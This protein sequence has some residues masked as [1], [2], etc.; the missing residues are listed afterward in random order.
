MTQ[1]PTLKIGFVGSGH[2][3]RVHAQALHALGGAE[4]IAWS[5]QRRERAL[6]A[7]RDFG[8]EA[9]T[10]DALLSHAGLEIAIITTPTPQHAEQAITA[11]THGKQVF[12][13]KPMARTA[14]QADD[15]IAAAAR[16]QRKLFIGHTLRFFPIYQQARQLILSGAVGN[17]R[18]VRCRRLNLS[19]AG[20]SPWFFDFE[21]SGGCILDL[22]IHDFDFLNWCFG[23]PTRVEVET[24]PDKDPSGW[25]HAI[26]HLYFE[27]GVRAAAEGSWMHDRFE[28]SLKVEGDRGTLSTDFA[29]NL[30][31]LEDKR[32]LRA[33]E[34]LAAD[35][36][37]DQMKHYLQYVRGEA[38]L[39]VT[40]QDAR[41][42]LGVALAGLRKLAINQ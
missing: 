36:Y 1:T 19:P 26:V 31:R 34:V 4:I 13:E 18:R 30:L 15:M 8:G 28:Q 29:G 23:A 42:A 16:L 25:R 6:A 21:Q 41:A 9:M 39:I 22:M 38:N 14:T 35:P 32:G 24:K 5:A 2:I 20:R 40:P 17:V 7:A 27:N 10:T 37:Y 11:M 33:L 12:C 3:A